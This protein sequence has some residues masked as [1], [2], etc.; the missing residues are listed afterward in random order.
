MLEK[1][2][3]SQTTKPWTHARE[4]NEEKRRHKRDGARIDVDKGVCFCRVAETHNTQ[5]DEDED[6]GRIRIV[7]RSLRKMA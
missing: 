1:K 4:Q 6:E 3:C 5:K 7:N 2:E